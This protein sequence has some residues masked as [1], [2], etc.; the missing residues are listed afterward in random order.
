MKFQL[1][2]DARVFK[3]W[4]KY[5]VTGSRRETVCLI[6]I[7]G[8]EETFAFG[9][10][11]CAASDRFVKVVGREIA[12]K[13]ALQYAIKQKGMRNDFWKAASTAYLHRAT[14]ARKE[15]TA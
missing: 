9:S 14:P 4:F 15:V 5:S 8:V 11:V 7:E 10:T 1:K 6:D 3:I 13:R 2:G 12:F